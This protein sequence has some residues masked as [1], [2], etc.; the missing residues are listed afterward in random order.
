M[1]AAKLAFFLF[2]YRHLIREF[3]PIVRALLVMLNGDR[4][5]AAELQGRADT[6]PVRDLVDFTIEAESKNRYS[7]LSQNEFARQMFK[8][9]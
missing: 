5:R 3:L 6:N 9:D 8:I 2:R 1:T 4:S 7:E